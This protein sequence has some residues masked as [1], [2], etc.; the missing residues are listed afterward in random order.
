MLPVQ[1]Q[2]TDVVVV[3][4]VRLQDGMAAAWACDAVTRHVA[5]AAERWAPTRV[6]A[7]CAGWLAV[8][9]AHARR[10]HPLPAGVH[11]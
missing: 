4:D 5:Q 7:G 9:W 8:Q 3:D 6:R 11:I 1:L 2:R 10:T